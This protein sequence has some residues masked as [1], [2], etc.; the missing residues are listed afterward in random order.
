MKFYPFVD[1]F[2]A[3]LRLF[4]PTLDPFVS[5]RYLILF[6]FRRLTTQS[7]SWIPWMR[8]ATRIQP[9]LC[10]SYEITSPY[11]HQ[12]LQVGHSYQFWVT[13][14][15]LIESLQLLTFFN[16]IFLINLSFGKVFFA[17]S[18]KMKKIFWVKGYSLRTLSVFGN[19]GKKCH[20]FSL[21]FANSRHILRKH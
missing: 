13:V 3:T 20:W 8:T 18:R 10:S 15:F 12:I 17:F 4:V 19:L 14:W 1:I 9:W 21:N 6:W 2:C 16:L 5:A 11:G 7:L